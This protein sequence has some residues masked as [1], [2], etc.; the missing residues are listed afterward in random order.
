MSPQAN[1]WRTFVT[2]SMFDVSVPVFRGRLNALSHV[3]AKAEANAAERKIDPK[4]LLASRLA[5][6]MLPLSSQ[7]Q[8]SS[9]HAK[10][11]PARLAGREVPKFEDNETTFDELQARI[12]R[13]VDFLNSF[14]PA[15]FEGSEARTV[16]MKTPTRELTFTGQVYLLGFAMPNFYFHVTTAYNILRH[17]GVPLG[18]RDFIHQN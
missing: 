9:D 14:A 12:A 6:D 16:V 13:T 7:V 4:V 3:L 17:N 5:P 1:Q 10:G 2:I 15:E 8:L 18:K 11:A